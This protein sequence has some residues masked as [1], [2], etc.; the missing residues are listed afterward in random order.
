[1]TCLDKSFVEMTRELHMP[2]TAQR[3]ALRSRISSSAT[4]RLSGSSV[5]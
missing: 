5:S 2:E 4:G 1:V 3:Q